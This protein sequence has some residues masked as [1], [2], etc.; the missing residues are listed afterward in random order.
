[1]SGG[2]PKGPRMATL[3]KQNKQREDND[4]EYKQQRLNWFQSFFTRVLRTSENPLTHTGTPACSTQTVSAAPIA[5]TL[6][7]PSPTFIQSS[8]SSG[9]TCC[10]H[11]A[12]ISR[13]FSRTSIASGGCG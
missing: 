4:P 8:I 12:K 2:A 11:A 5:T 7:K 13:T 6:R 10:R 1:M 3:E 9:S